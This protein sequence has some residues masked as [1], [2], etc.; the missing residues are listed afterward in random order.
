MAALLCL[1]LLV[2][3]G[4]VFRGEPHKV[5]HNVHRVA[6]KDNVLKDEESLGFREAKRDIVSRGKARVGDHKEHVGVKELQHPTLGPQEQ[7][8]FE[9]QYSLGTILLETIVGLV[10]VL[11]LDGP[12]LLGFH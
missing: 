4:T 10:C 12:A 2:P 8:I 11:P 7:L 6:S 9:R 5:K 3:V 1:F